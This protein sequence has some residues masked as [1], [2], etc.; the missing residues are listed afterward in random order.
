MLRPRHSTKLIGSLAEICACVGLSTLVAA[1][2][3]EINING[4]F[5]VF[6]PTIV[7]CCWLHGF[8]GA[9]ASSLLSAIDLWYFFVPPPGFALPTLADT[10]HLFIFL[11]VAI[12][13]C[14][15]LDRER[16]ANALLM[17]ENFELGYKVF[18]LR[19]IRAVREPAAR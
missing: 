4:Q 6:L 9:V 14:R 19:E 12:F 13:V 18:L 8:R 15:M 2:L 3:A 17:Q 5:Q 16:R 1:G 10:G 11:G 7:F